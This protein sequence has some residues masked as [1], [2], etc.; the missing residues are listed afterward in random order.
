[1]KEVR[2][3]MKVNLKPQNKIVRW[4]VKKK[5]KFIMLR[6]KGNSIAKVQLALNKNKKE[7]V[8]VIPIHKED[9]DNYELISFVQCFKILHDHQIYVLAPENLTIQKYREAVTNFQVIFIDP[10]W[11]ASL[12]QYNKLKVSLFFYNLFKSYDFLLTYEL[13]AFVF[14]DELF[15]WCSMQYDYIGAPWF[16]GHNIP[17]E[18]LQL[19]GVGNSGFSLR[20]VSASRRILKRILFLQNLRKFWFNSYLQSVIKFEKVL[21]HWNFLFKIKDFQNL[22]DIFFFDKEMYEDRYW[23]DFIPSLFSDFTTAS[24]ETAI[25]FSFEVNPSLLYEMNNQTLPFGC[26]AWR[27]F[28]Q[29][30]WEKF[31]DTKLLVANNNE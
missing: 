6:I 13:D 9:P 1:M 26:H 22:R 15:A 24:I 5:R 19:I 25:Q 20:R 2:T 7:C 11:Q 28:E 14:K 17:V 8:V 30:F 12:K 31:I 21:K 3:E 27:T 23:S 18:P 4:E 10:I 16:K 29:E